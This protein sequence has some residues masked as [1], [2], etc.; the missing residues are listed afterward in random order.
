MTR[1][2]IFVHGRSQENKDASQLKAEWIAAWRKGLAQNG[3]DLPIAEADIRFPYY[4]QALYDLVQGRPQEEI[5]NVIVRGHSVGEAEAMFVRSVILETQTRMGITD[6]QVRTAAGDVAIEKGV[7][8]WEW[9]HSVLK[10]LDKHVPGASGASVAIATRDVYLY[11]KNPG[12]QRA[13]HAGILPAFEHDGETVVVAH[14][15]G[16]VVAYNM[17]RSHG[18]SLEWNVPLFITLG[19][20]LAVGAV[21]SALEPCDHPPCVSAWFNAL[22]EGDVVALYPLDENHFPVEPPIE[23]KTDVDNPT[24]NQHGITGYLSDPVVAARIHHTLTQ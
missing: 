16:T 3:L 9:V 24:P 18:T 2:L 21:K 15:L 13:I 23:N 4:G 22:D 5:A 19:S 11:L 1:R 20:P 12:F 10:A 14:S 6:E 8:N 7:L 17:L